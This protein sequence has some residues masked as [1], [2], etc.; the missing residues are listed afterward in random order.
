MQ[1][2]EQITIANKEHYKI[3]HTAITLGNQ[4]AVQGLLDRNIPLDA[5]ILQ[6][7]VVYGNDK[8]L[9]ILLDTTGHYC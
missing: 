8:I 6:S 3:L 1:Y 7:A 9:G 4:T 2:L 5:E